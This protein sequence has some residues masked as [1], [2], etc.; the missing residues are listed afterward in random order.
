MQRSIRR[1]DTGWDQPWKQVHLS[2]NRSV[3]YL[4][5]C[6]P[7]FPTT[8][9]TIKLV[10]IF[11]GNI[12]PI[13]Q[14]KLTKSLIIKGSNILSNKTMLMKEQSICQFC[15][16]LQKVYEWKIYIQKEF[17]QGHYIYMYVS[18]PQCLLNYFRF[19]Q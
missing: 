14:V 1:L 19:L 6:P 8:H 12:T 11:S 18:E 3:I 7:S 17:V 13:C 2:K 4:N 10:V 15:D 5:N 9:L 16:Q